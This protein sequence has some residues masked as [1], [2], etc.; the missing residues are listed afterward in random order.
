MTDHSININVGQDK[1]LDLDADEQGQFIAFT[2]SKTV[3][4]NGTSLTIDKEIR[5]PIIRR[6]DLETFLIA[7]SRTDKL[8]NGHIYDFNGQLIKSFLIGDGIQDIIIHNKRI[9]ATYFDEGVYGEDGPNNDGLA[10][11]DLFGQQIFGINSSVEELGID[12][13]YCIC[14]KNK[15]AVLFYAYSD[16]KVSE[17]NLDRFEIASFDTPNDFSGASAIS[18]TKDNIIFYSSYHDKTSFFNWDKDKNEVTKFGSYSPLLKGI[19]NGKFLAFGDSGF[20][21]IDTVD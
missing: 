7:D 6:L 11:F 3:I 14:K 8:P 20:T 13:C 9:V 15:K 12:D 19:G 16:F 5:F 10:V 1:I 2:N 18:S 4:T 17:L 21:I